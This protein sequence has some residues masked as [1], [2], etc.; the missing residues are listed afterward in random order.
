[1]AG[2]DEIEQALARHPEIRA[3]AVLSVPTGRGEKNVI[4]YVETDSLSSEQI[5]GFLSDSGLSQRVLPQVVVMMTALP[6]TFRGKVD[7]EALPLPPIHCAVPAGKAGLSP[8]DGRVVGGVIC[9][10]IFAVF[11]LAFTGTL[12]PGSTDLALVPTPWSWWFRGL[13]AAEVISFGAGV[14]FVLLAWPAMARLG[15]PLGRTLLAFVAIAWLLLAWWPQDNFYRLTAKNDWPRQ[16]ALV[17]G[18]NV[19]L[20]LAALAVVAFVV[21][22]P[23]RH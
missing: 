20:M 12:W 3:S 15:R 7:R 17:Y 14:A 8:T 18:F 16:A 4:A 6:R 22:A 10:A 9:T 5:Q 19:T 21:S 11:A 13:Y 2:H 23:R 1:M